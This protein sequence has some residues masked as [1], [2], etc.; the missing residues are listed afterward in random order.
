MVNYI[1][2]DGGT[3]NTRVSLVCDNKV[4]LTEKIAVGAGSGSK[5]ELKNA[6]KLAVRSVLSERSLTES[7]IDVYWLRE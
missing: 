1:T 7:D 2:V 5:T 3:T 6:I 4:I